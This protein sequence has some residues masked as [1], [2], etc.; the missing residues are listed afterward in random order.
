M[1]AAACGSPAT[2]STTASNPLSSGG[3][4]AQ[5]CRAGQ[6]E[7]HLAFWSG[8][9]QSLVDS[10]FAAFSEKYPGIHLSYNFL[11]GSTIAEKLITAH[12]AG[13]AQSVDMIDVSPDEAAPL[14]H[15]NLLDLKVAWKSYDIP[16]E[17]VNQQDAVEWQK[18]AQGLMYNTNL[19][20]ASAL[21]DTWQGLLSSKWAGKIIQDPRGRPFDTLALAWGESQALTFT[22]ELKN[23][24]PQLF[25]GAST[26][27]A[28]V[29]SGQGWMVTGGDAVDNAIEQ[30]A[31]AP[32]AMKY[33]DY[34]PLDGSYTM[35][36]AHAPD[37][38]AAVCFTSWLMSP[39]G[40]RLTA[41][42]GYVNANLQSEGVP[43]TSKTVQIETAA[44]ANEVSTVAA[45]EAALWAGS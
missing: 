9:E 39:T 11:D 27:A 25:Q 8:D 23:F 4:L 31:G 34:V 38:D 1:L 22:K 17:D 21:P 28:A 5:V 29:A 15:R 14:I 45:K 12:A 16:A 37:P 7:A 44:Q 36:M 3:T 2:G 42:L 30:A 19:V 18:V 40:Q 6:K 24:H 41:G 33:L 20:K 10:L 26:G 13:Q 43:S 35:L 32:V